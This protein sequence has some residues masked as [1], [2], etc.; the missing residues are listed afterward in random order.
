LFNEVRMQQLDDDIGH[1]LDLRK[2]NENWL[3]YATE[4]RLIAKIR[5]KNI[6]TK[7]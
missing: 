7:K 3:W 4:P 2:Y 6:R 5:T 1:D